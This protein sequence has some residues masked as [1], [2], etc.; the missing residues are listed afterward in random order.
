MRTHPDLQYNKV[1]TKKNRLQTK[2]A[3]MSSRYFYITDNEYRKQQNSSFQE[4]VVTNQK[5]SI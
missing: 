3:Q 1:K 2:R 5:D 4:T